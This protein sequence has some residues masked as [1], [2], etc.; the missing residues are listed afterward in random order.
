MKKNF[1]Q[2]VVPSSSKRSIRDIPLPNHKEVRTPR[3]PKMRDV[4]PQEEVFETPTYSSYEEP[5]RAPEPHAYQREEVEEEEE[6]EAPRKPHKRKKSGSK[7]IIMAVGIG[8]LI[9]FA[10]LIGQTDA[11]ITITPKKTTAEVAIVIPTD[12]TNKLATK[13]QLSKSASKTLPATGE[14]QVE[15]QASGK[16]RITNKHK[17]AP[18]ELVKNTRFQAPNGLIYRIRDSIV[19]PGYTMNGGTMVPGTLDVEVFADSAGEDYNTSGQVKFTIPGFSGKEQ[20]D[21]ITAE[22]IGDITG[23]YIGIQKVVSD[24]AKEQ[25]RKDL[26]QDLQNQFSQDQ[27]Q[28]TE[29]VLVP[30]M[31]T[32]SFGEL[33][34]KA[35]GDSVVLTLTARVDAYSFVKKDLSNFIGQNSISGASTTDTFTLDTSKLAFLIGEDGIKVSGTSLI[36]YAT[37]SEKL[38]KDFAGKKR[39]EIAKIIDGYSSFE[40]AKAELKPFWKSSFPEDPSKIEVIIQE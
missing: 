8:V 39:S 17:D 2:D 32:L 18:Q 26:E 37:E 14:Q 34:D 6:Y 9:F 36:T 40:N 38:Q 22:N 35:Q 33:Q 30:D 20:F 5:Q 10:I 7:K 31:S 12:G 29:Y 28:S 1:L 21:K 19:I 25:A 15:K 23:G 24:E 27:N 13:T 16:I 11:K 4:E 3:K